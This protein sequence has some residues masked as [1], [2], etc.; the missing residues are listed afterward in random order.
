[1]KTLNE[2]L[3]AVKLA[4]P[5]ARETG[6]LTRLVEDVTNAMLAADPAD[7]RN[8]GMDGPRRAGYYRDQVYGVVYPRAV[9]RAVK[10]A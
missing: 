1:M 3:D 5:E 2:W 6:R 10:A 4:I 7:L 8:Q 9:P